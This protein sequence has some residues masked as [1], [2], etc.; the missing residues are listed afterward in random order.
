MR[1]RAR[2]DSNHV[3]LVKVFR[4]MGAE[5]ID[6]AQLGDGIPDLLVTVGKAYCLVEIKDGSKPPS[7]QA[8]TKDELTFHQKCRGNLKIINRVE[9]AVGLVA[10]MRKELE[11]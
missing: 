9:T 4:D 10:D 3:E 7:Q 2:K 8:L 6:L 5:V 11:E 1:L